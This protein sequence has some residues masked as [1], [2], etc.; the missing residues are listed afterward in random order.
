M[1]AY[2]GFESSNPAVVSAKRAIDCRNLLI[3][4]GGLA[5]AKESEVK[6]TIPM[7]IRPE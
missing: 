7:A 4:I 3:V 6:A 5:P 1:L 2:L